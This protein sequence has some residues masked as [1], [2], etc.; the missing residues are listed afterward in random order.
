MGYAAAQ[1]IHDLTREDLLAGVLLP[2]PEGARVVPP[3]ELVSRVVEGAFMGAG[4][5]SRHLEPG[6]LFVALEGENVDGRRFA[7]AVLEAGHWVLTRGEGEADPLVGATLPAGTGALL[8]GD[9]EKALA[10]LARCWRG[11]LN[12]RVLAI[13]GTNGKTTTKD[14]ARALLGGGG[15]VQ[16]TRGNFNNQLGLPITLLRL[17]PETRFGVIEMGASAVGDISYL[18]RIARP[19]VGLITNASPAHLEKFG[20]LENIIAG[21][22]E[23]LEELPAEGRAVLN[24]DSPGFEAWVDRGACP[25]I[26]WGRQSGDHRWAYDGTA[27]HLILDGEAWPVPLPGEHNAANLCA[28]ILAGRAL[29]LDDA[30]LRAG[31]AAFVASDHRSRLLEWG[32]RRIL[33]DSYNAN[34]GSVRAAARTIVTL[35]GTGRKLAVLGRMAELGPTADRLH[36]ETGAAL[37]ELGIDDLLAVGDGA[38]ALAAGFGTDARICATCAEALEWLREN[39]GAGDAILVK[40]SRSAG[41]DQLVRLMEEEGAS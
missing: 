9:P 40:G 23:L 6:A 33:D 27:G 34:P 41:M 13:T 22:G 26:S 38:A 4:L 31:L 1:A 24:A 11:R 2:G 16:A 17:R 5:D 8:S 12:T 19:D 25:V 36:R 15:T 37:A 14:L 29:G 3:A 20:T 30:S 18:A 35:H 7:P 10:C 39:T 21:K 28:A 32:G